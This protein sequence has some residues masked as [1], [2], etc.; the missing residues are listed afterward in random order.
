MASKQQS[1]DSDQVCLVLNLF[2][3]FNLPGC[4][5]TKICLHLSPLSCFPLSTLVLLANY[6]IR[7]HHISVFK[8]ALPRYMCPSLPVDFKPQ[9]PFHTCPLPSHA[10]LLHSGTLSVKQSS[11]SLTFLFHISCTFAEIQSWLYSKFLS[12]IYHQW[13]LLLSVALSK[14]QGSANFLLPTV[15]SRLVLFVHYLSRTVF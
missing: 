2:A 3:A 9:P 10:F 11:H 14:E 1:Q 4:L 7:C 6:P 5:A 12:Q 15:T 8:N 13:S